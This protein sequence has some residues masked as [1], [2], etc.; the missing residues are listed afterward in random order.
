MK[1]SPSPS[2]LRVLAGLL[3]I[4]TEESLGTLQALATEQAWLQPS[5]RQ[6]AEL[7]LTEWRAQHTR[8]FINGYPKTCCPPFESAYREGIM[9]GPV[10]HDIGHFYHAIGLQPIEGLPPDYLG[11]LLECAAYLLEQDPVSS[12][13]WETL[14]QGHL[15]Q[16]VPKFAED[17]ERHTELHLYQQLAL[18]LKD[19]F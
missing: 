7:P 14:W 12:S 18:Q 17:L 5:L 13:D 19:L 11:V 8:L 1:N 10:C 4:P 9:N 3:A 15:A 6:L 16:W 2:L